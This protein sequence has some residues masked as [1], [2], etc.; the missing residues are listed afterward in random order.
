MV[1]VDLPEL[2]DG[3]CRFF[4]ERIDV[5]LRFASAGRS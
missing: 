2:A 5:N 1:V 4:P 3:S